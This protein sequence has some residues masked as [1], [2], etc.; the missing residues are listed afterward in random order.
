MTGSLMFISLL[1]LS[2]HNKADT[3]FGLLSH[4]IG[5]KQ[6]ETSTV[7]IPQEEG[8]VLKYFP[9]DLD[10]FIKLCVTKHSNTNK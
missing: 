5:G 6:P 8:N 10:N 9:N 3:H 1:S 2:V 7:E 4:Q